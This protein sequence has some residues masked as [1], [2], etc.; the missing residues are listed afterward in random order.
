[1][2]TKRFFYILCAITAGL[3]I[4]GGVAYY[5]ASRNLQAGTS[6]LSRRLADEQLADAKISDLQDL[7]SQY[8]RLKPLIPVIY[9]A[10]PDQKNQSQI[11]IQLRNI[12]SQSGM[13]LDSLSFAASTS[14]GPISQT[15]KVGDVLAVPISFQLGGSYAQLQ[16]FLNL[17]E[18]LNRYTNMTSLT[19]SG[20]DNQ[21]KFDVSLNAF[22]K[23]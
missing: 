9:A 7:E 17:Q 16:T 12:A 1:M 19:I 3:L 5:Y 11:A 13:T 23:P 20:T 2:S 18:H 22:V 6:E 14:P 10:L 15:V 4:V 8:Q 21:L